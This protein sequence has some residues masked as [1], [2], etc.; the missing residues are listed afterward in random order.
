MKTV[1]ITGSGSGL[2]SELAY[3]FSELDYKVCLLG[4]T[5]YKLEEVSQNLKGKSSIFEVDITD[6]LSVAEV[7]KKIDESHDA[8][9]C[10]VNNA[11]V[12]IFKSLA[13]MDNKEVDLLIDTNVKGAIYCTKEVLPDMQ[14]RNKGDILNIISNSGKAAKA[15]EIIYSTSKFGMRG[16]SEAL[17]D[18]TKDTD[19]RVLAAYMGNMNTSLWREDK[20]AE[21]KS[22]ASPKDMT[23]I[24]MDHFQDRENVVSSDIVIENQ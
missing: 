5:R 12:G 23:K 10:L 16:F 17:T 1:V 6:P 18:L 13:E 15:D 14:R 19:I 20:P 4:R 8:I 2:G 24:I 22:Y 3:A 7:F 9:D 21:R 11:G